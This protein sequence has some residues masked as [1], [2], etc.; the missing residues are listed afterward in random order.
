MKNVIFALRI[1]K[2]DGTVPKVL[3]V[4]SV[5]TIFSSDSF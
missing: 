3:A 5:N 1:Y 2:Q 4:L